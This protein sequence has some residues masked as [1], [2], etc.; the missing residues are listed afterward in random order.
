GQSLPALDE[1]LIDVGLPR[2]E[3]CEAIEVGDTVTFACEL[4]ELND[5]VYVGR[6]F[7]DRIGT[8][9]MLDAME[10]LGA[11]TVDVYAVSSVQEEVGV[12]GMPMAAYAIEPDMGLA[13]DGSVTWGAHIPKHELLCALGEG[14]GIYI[15]D[16]L[17]IGDR[18]LVQFLFD[19]CEKNGIAYQRNIGGGTDAS[20]IQRTKSGA[21]STTVGAPVRYMHSTVQL[22]HEDDI[23]ATVALLKTFLEHAHELNF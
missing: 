14:T 16:R 3:V 20:A 19:L 21:L 15:M 8:Y 10:H 17:T 4:A 22:C 12:R 6:N 9:C 1:M 11:T 18:R 5:K 2:E 23:E 13:L 7:D